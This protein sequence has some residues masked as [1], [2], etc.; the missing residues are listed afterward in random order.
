MKTKVTV[1]ETKCYPASFLTVSYNGV[2]ERFY[3]AQHAYSRAD[4][5]RKNGMKK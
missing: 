1:K 4:Y 3:N 2:N 5:L